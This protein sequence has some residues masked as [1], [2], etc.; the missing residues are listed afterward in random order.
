MAAWDQ[1]I[2]GAPNIATAGNYAQM[3]M[4]GLNPQRPQQQQNQPQAGMMPQQNNYIAQLLRSLY[5]NSSAGNV[6][7]SV[8]PSA[9]S[10]GNA[11]LMGAW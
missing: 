8:P 3:L 1:D 11:P 7:P 10:A 4:S 5:G 2:P 6:Q 9:P